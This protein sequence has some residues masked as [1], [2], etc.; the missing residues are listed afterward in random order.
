MKKV[1]WSNLTFHQQD[2]KS[3]LIKLTRNLKWDTF[4]ISNFLFKGD[5][6]FSSLVEC[7]IDIEKIISSSLIF[8]KPTERFLFWP[9]LT[10]IK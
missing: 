9:D 6:D 2:I 4:F 5:K 1:M 8:P 3:N 10:I 7:C